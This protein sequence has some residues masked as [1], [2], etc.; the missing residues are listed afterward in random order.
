MKVKNSKLNLPPTVAYNLP[1]F[2]HN[3]YMMVMPSKF[4]D[5]CNEKYGE[6]YN[7]NLQGRMIT[8]ASGKLGEETMK[9]DADDLSI[10]QGIVRGKL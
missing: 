8:V 3:L 4:L 1:L 7:L 6:I 2:G 10:A 9:A 5:W